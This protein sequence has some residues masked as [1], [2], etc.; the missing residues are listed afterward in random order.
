MALL[1]PSDDP[2]VR[3]TPS[4]HQRTNHPFMCLMGGFAFI[5][6]AALAVHVVFNVL[7]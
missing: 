4:E 3:R 6:G 2:F 5:V 1:D 7:V